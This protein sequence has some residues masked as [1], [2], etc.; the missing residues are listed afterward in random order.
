MILG[1]ALI[2]TVLG[3]Q[4]M[5]WDHS[6]RIEAGVAKSFGDRGGIGRED[7]RPIA[8]VRRVVGHPQRADHDAVIARK[9]PREQACDGW[10]GP[11]RLG[12]VIE[13]GYR[14]WVARQLVNGRAGLSLKAI[15]A[16]LVGTACVENDKQDARAAVLG[17]DSRSIVDGP[18][19]D[20]GVPRRLDEGLDLVTMFRSH[21]GLDL[22]T[23]LICERA[24]G[25]KHDGE[26]REG[27]EE[28]DVRRVDASA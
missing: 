9:Q 16:Q 21:E 20:D 3:P 24:S 15:A 18:E 19:R 27:D 12:V 23:I 28:F 10:L 6:E 13:K 5:R 2:K 1:K 11:W 4:M 22:T 26:D 25:Q 7:L 14:V 8:A 17:S